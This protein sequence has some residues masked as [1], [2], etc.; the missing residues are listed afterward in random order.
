MTLEFTR[1]RDF[2]GS[3][4]PT[5]A[6]AGKGQFSPILRGVS[7]SLGKVSI[8]ENSGMVWAESSY[9]Y[10][11]LYVYEIKH[12]KREGVCLSWSS[13]NQTRSSLPATAVT[14]ASWG[15][16][17]NIMKTNMASRIPLGPGLRANCLHIYGKMGSP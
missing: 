10:I 6:L 8:G 14:Q 16:F 7:G 11:Y 15:V 12:I 9:T 2:G 4:E 5:D 1:S 3:L 17:F 13:V